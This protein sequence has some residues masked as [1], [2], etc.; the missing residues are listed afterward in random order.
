MC[1][2][3]VLKIKN[4]WTRFSTGGTISKRFGHQPI[5]QGVG[6]GGVGWLK[7]S[8]EDH[9]GNSDGGCTVQLRELSAHTLSPRGREVSGG[10]RWCLLRGGGFMVC[11]YCCTYLLM[12]CMQQESSDSLNCWVEV[13]PAAD[14]MPPDDGVQLSGRSSGGGGKTTG[15]TDWREEAT[16]TPGSRD[17]ARAHCCCNHRGAK[18]TALGCCKAL[19]YIALCVSEKYHTEYWFVHVVINMSSM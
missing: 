2:A 11:W 10:E 3:R 17:E 15:A 1:T 16:S 19:A 13:L 5:K 18:L 14:L 4:F 12:Q 8:C 7:I 6:N 9:D